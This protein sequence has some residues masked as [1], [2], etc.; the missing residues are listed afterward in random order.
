[1][2]ESHGSRREDPRA[3]EIGYHKSSLIA[4][5]PKRTGDPVFLENPWNSESLSVDSFPSELIQKWGGE[6]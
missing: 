6:K 5:L 2:T 3:F 4:G 1:M